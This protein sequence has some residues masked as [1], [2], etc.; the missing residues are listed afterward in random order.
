MHDTNNSKL[1]SLKGEEFNL[2]EFLE[3]Y[4][5]HWKW[6]ALGLILA[7]AGAFI[8]L[9]Y[10]IPQ[11][12]VESTILIQDKENESIYSELTAFEDLELVS[13]SKS[14]FSTE[15]GVLKSRG[16]MERV[17][18][19]LELNKTYYAKG[20]F[21]NS[22]L[23]GSSLPFKINF[24]GKDSTLIHL[25]TLLSIIP[26]SQT[27]FALLNKRGKIIGNH[28]FGENIVS[29][30][31]D[32]TVTPTSL[33]PIEIGQKIDISIRPIEPVADSYRIK[34][35]IEPVNRKSSLINMS[36]IG[37][38]KEKSHD[39]IAVLL[40]Q[41]IKE[42]IIDKSLIAG[43]TDK[44][45]AERIQAISEELTLVDNDV[46]SFKAGN[47]L[48]NLDTQTDLFLSSNTT[49]EKETLD[50]TTQLKLTDYVFNH[51]DKNNNDLLPTN[52]GLPGISLNE[53]TLRY[54]EIL[55]ERNRL[56]QSTND[57]NP[58]ILNLDNQINNLKTSIS[59]S[60]MNLKSTL[61][62]SLSDLKNQ[63]YQLGSKITAIPKKERQFRDIQR[64]QQTIEALYLYLLQKREEN[65]ISLAVKT[66]N[67]K[68]IDT[69]YAKPGQAFPKRM[70]IFAIASVIGLSIPFVLL[71]LLFLVDNKIHSI[72]ELNTIS[73]VPILGGV[74]RYKRKNKLLLSETD[75]T[76][77][78][79]VF[80]V[81]RT[82]M[83]F[84]LSKPTEGAKTIFVTSTIAGE[85]KTLT[86]INLAKIL[87]MSSKKVLLIG[88]DIRNPKLAAYLKIPKKEGLSNYL[89]TDSLRAENLIEH[90][91]SINLDVLQAGTHSPNPS[92]LF[93][94]GRFDQLLAHAKANYDYIIVDTA[95]VNLVT[96]T[97]VLSEG[98]AD[99]NVYVVR[100]N[101]LDKRMIK[102]LNKLQESGQLQHL[103][104]V[105][106]DINSKGLHGYNYNYGSMNTL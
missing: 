37:A 58:V 8:Y 9:R 68:I 49:L 20:R 69:P 90:V 62:I 27:E 11:Y 38:N 72:D 12:E 59:Q 54:N 57:Q 25:D 100:A 60:L 1:D 96:D 53:S 4:I 42:S 105:L 16:L 7:L 15:I 71:Y 46:Q 29:K 64:R 23:Y 67:A 89:A 80:R 106:N 82:N 63:E 34:T 104:V 10:T 44:F 95:P 22:E 61:A 66:P 43:N 87:S 19:K 30:I 28:L 47:N 56:S 78:T 35:K 51:L 103:A 45:I 83:H 40:E 14:Q 52:L 65:A 92:E 98:R 85:G 17:V 33:T 6:F 75:T 41:Y 81:L 93:M 102:V 55:L 18:E 77:M 5:Y 3:K 31:G 32:F 74:P 86:A 50:L 13:N 97:I 91:S 36:L 48:T 70:F 24:F 39:I 101:Y 21:R 73:S 88:G 94:N 2:R 84:M 76:S 99:L 79:D 26:S